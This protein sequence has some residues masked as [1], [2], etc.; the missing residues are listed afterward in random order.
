[1]GMCR[2]LIICLTSC[3]TTL[4]FVECLRA[5]G[6]DT[7]NALAWWCQNYVVCGGMSGFYQPGMCDGLSPTI[8]TV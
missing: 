2:D 7:H 4:I 3:D 1:M 8:A 6:C 5:C